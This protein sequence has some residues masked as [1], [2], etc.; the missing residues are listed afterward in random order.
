MLLKSKSVAAIAPC[1]TDGVNYTKTSP[2]T[3]YPPTW[4]FLCKKMPCRKTAEHKKSGSGIKQ[5]GESVSVF[6]IYVDDRAVIIPRADGQYVSISLAAGSQP[7]V[8]IDPGDALAG[9]P[10][11]PDA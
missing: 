9:K 10:S 6:C 4:R 1:S 5:F 2:I 7:Q 11:K 8:D 3:D